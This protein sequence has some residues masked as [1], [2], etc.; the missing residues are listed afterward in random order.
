MSVPLTPINPSETLASLSPE[1]TRQILE[2]A[3]LTAQEPLPETG[4]CAA[5][6]YQDSGSNS[7]LWGLSYWF[8]TL[9]QVWICHLGHR[10]LHGSLTGLHGIQVG[11]QPAG[12]DQFIVRPHLLDLALFDDDDLIGIANQ[13]ELMRDDDSGLAFHQFAQRLQNQVR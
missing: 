7:Q 12:T 9:S 2:A 1:K 3:L 5:D 13:I 11:V 10:G 4:R 6:R 8:S